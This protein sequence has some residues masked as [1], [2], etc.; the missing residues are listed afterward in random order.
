VDRNDPTY[1]D[2]NVVD[3]TTRGYTPVDDV[4]FP[5]ADSD[6]PPEN[7]E[8][9]SEAHGAEEL[10]GAAVGGAVGGATEDVVQEGNTAPH[11]R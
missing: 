10:G 7:P 8:Q 9:A 3:P 2:D 4:S 5:G 11:D 6:T 1:R